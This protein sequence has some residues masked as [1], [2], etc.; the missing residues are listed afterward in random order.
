[1]KAERS[2]LSAE[3]QLH[4]VPVLRQQVGV[5]GERHEKGDGPAFSHELGIDNQLLWEE[6]QR[7]YLSHHVCCRQV[8][9]RECQRGEPGSRE[10]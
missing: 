2:E 4:R 8:L 9:F 5:R 3:H 7:H 6:A 10:S 1:M